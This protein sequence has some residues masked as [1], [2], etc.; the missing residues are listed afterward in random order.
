[1]AKQIFAKWQPA[2]AAAGIPTIPVDLNKQPV[3]KGYQRATLWASEQYAL[4]FP[5]NDAFGFMCRRARITVL[6]VDAPDERLL[7]DMLDKAGPTPIVVQSGSG[8]YQ[9]WYR[10]NGEPRDIRR[11]HGKPVD[12]LGDGL[13]IAPPS[14]LAKGSYRF[15][16]G[17]LDDLDRL[18]KMKQ[19]DAATKAKR[20]GEG[21]RGIALWRH[22]M[23]QAPHCD[24][25]DALL[26]VAFTFA[27][28]YLDL[29]DGHPFTPAQIRRAA[30]SAWTYET[31][32]N[33]AF[34]RGGEVTLVN[35]EMIDALAGQQPDALA[36]YILLRR[37]HAGRADFILANALAK[38]L[39]WTLP[40]FK[41][42][43]EALEEEGHIRCIHPGG[44]GPN[45][46][47]VYGWG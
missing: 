43:R 44:R 20:I 8:N 19:L 10:Y 28:D 25:L 11:W 16:E 6:D 30:E 46:P 15:I 45:D 14:R 29:T 24:D 23:R 41:R 3:V 34:G 35:N 27:D 7:A 26:D 5:A 17:G 9:A 39:G 38:S 22:L 37:H 13:V 1:M 36:L 12:I 18:P 42:A 2:Y 47:P 21:E 31:T 40:R 4:K 33:N 32:G